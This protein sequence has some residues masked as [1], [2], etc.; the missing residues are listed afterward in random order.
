MV[1]TLREF[2]SERA[3]IERSRAD[4][5]KD[6]QNEWIWAVRRLNEQIKDWL[7]DADQE[8]LLK[9]DERQYEIREIDVGV[10]TVPGLVIRM[11]AREVRTVPIARMIVGPELSNGMI[12]VTRSFGR[13]DLTDGGE[14]FMLFRSQKEPSDEWV[15]VE[16]KS[17]TLKKFDREAFEE[18]TQS[19]L[20]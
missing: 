3:E 4:V 19:L 9:I 1:K 11:D 10:Y 14:K 15:I 16:E 13:V 7:L 6:L 20:E 17:Y 2:L 12:R 18:A 5:K 8:R